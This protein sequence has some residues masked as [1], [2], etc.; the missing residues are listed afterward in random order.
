MVI[1]QDERRRKRAN[2]NQT[3]GVTV[4]L[5]LFTCLLLKN[6]KGEPGRP[7]DEQRSPI[8]FFPTLIIGQSRPAAVVYFRSSHGT[9]MNGAGQVGN[10]DSTHTKRINDIKYRLVAQH[11][12]E[13]CCWAFLFCPMWLPA[14]PKWRCVADPEFKHTHK[15]LFLY[16][17]LVIIKEGR[18]KYS[19]AAVI[20]ILNFLFF[21]SVSRKITFGGQQQP[22]LCLETR[23]LCRVQ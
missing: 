11:G 9:L 22:L 16:I 12:R 5:L 7:Y 19:H 8:M 6:L 2:G 17:L 23:P 10:R 14:D 13:I 15:T 1:R 4:S 18:E 20:I 21:F 3:V